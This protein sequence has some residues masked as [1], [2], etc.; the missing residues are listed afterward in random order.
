MID[1]KETVTIS[2]DRYKELL[3]IEERYKD[4]CKIKWG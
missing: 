1:N 4:S 2:L 3:R